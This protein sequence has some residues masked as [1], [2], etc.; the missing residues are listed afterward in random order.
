MLI[1][2]NGD[3]F[4]AGVELADDLIPDYPGTLPYNA[5]AEK[6]SKSQDWIKKTYTDGNRLSEYRKSILDKL[7]E[8][9]HERSFPSTLGKIL[10]CQVINHAYGGSSIERIVRTSISDLI[11]LKDKHEKIF[12]FIGTTEIS[13]FEV[14][15][16]HAAYFK[17]KDYCGHY[18]CWK[19]I[20]VNAIHVNESEDANKLV[21]YHIKY[22]KNY[23]SYVR[24]FKNIIQLQDFCKNNGINLFWIS[25]FMNI[26]DYFNIEIEYRFNEDHDLTNFMNYAKFEYFLDMHEVAKTCN[27]NN[28]VCPSGHFSVDVHNLI[29]ELIHKKLKEQNYV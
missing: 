17:Y 4:I 26:L 6:T 19:S 12:A 27:L 29:A 23:H 20:N 16:P 13:R 24:T 28:V 7:V 8:T 10:N 18:Q 9:E 5:P 15:S 11:K 22:E 21:D 14:A 1:Y 3:S 2:A 25:S